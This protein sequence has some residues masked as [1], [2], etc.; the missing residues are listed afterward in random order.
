M[1]LQN[2]STER[3]NGFTSQLAKLTAKI[4]LRFNIK[5]RNFL[6]HFKRELVK[7]AQRQHPEYRNVQLAMRTGVDRRAVA[8]A[9][10]TDEDAPIWNGKD[11]L[12]LQRVHDFCERYQINLIP[13]HQGIESFKHICEASANGTLTAEAIATELLRIGAITNYGRFYKVNIQESTLKLQDDEIA[14]QKMIAGI[15]ELLRELS[16]DNCVQSEFFA[17]ASQNTYSLPK[18]HSLNG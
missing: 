14:R 1:A 13:K 7:E 12:V 4:V 17:P 6:A 15:S 18:H 2:K 8:E 5:Y 10:R 11:L 3:L 9:L 16:S